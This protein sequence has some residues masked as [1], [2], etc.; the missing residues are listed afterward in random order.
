MRPT[1]TVLTGPPGLRATGSTSTISQIG[2]AEASWTSYCVIGS[3]LLRLHVTRFSHLQNEDN[4]CICLRELLWGLNGLIY[5]KCLKW[6]L[7]HSHKWQLVQ[8]IINSS[9][10][11]MNIS[12]SRVIWSEV[13]GTLWQYCGLPKPSPCPIAFASPPTQRSLRKFGNGRNIWKNMSL[14]RNY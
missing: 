13:A 8:L 11:A 14:P 3:K 10:S 9:S 4:G 7:A 1:I 6:D 12:R 2:H 5:I